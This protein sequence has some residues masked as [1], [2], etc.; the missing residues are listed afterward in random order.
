MSEPTLMIPY[1]FVYI[2]SYPWD[3]NIE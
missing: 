2:W 3:K 1:N